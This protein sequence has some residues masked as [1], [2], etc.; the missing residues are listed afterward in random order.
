M[1]T[2]SLPGYSPLYKVL[3]YEPEVKKDKKEPVLD[4]IKLKYVKQ[5]I[6]L[7]QEHNIKLIFAASPRY[8]TETDDNYNDP[9]KN[10]CKEEN[11]EFID[12][13][14]TEYFDSHREYFQDAGHLNDTGA[15][16]YTKLFIK[17]LR[18]RSII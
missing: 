2:S 4:D 9:I 10:I 15:K 18:N 16:I 6:E 3:D 14:S 13:F 5:F 8:K 1:K 12:Y 17:E 11:I 7:C